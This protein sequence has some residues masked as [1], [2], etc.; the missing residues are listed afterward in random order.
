MRSGP[1]CQ[2]SK[3]RNRVLLLGAWRATC[4]RGLMECAEVLGDGE[5]GSR[6]FVWWLVFGSVCFAPGDGAQLFSGSPL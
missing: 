2:G 5:V 1:S 6:L 4:G 3:N